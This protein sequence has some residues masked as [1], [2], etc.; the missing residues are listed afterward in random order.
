LPELFQSFCTALRAQFPDLQLF[1]IMRNLDDPAYWGGESFSP[2]TYRLVLQ[3]AARGLDIAATDSLMVTGEVGANLGLRRAGEDIDLLEA[4]AES[5]E[6][7]SLV[8]AFAVTVDGGIASPYDR[9]ADV[10][11]QNLS[12]VIL[13][14]EA[15]DTAGAGEMPIWFTHFGWTGA[16]AGVI[17]ASEQASYVE[18]GMRRA[19]SEWAWAG[20]IFNWQLVEAQEVDQSQLA[21]LADGQSLPLL[22]AMADFGNSSLGRSITTG[23]VPPDAPA[24]DYSGNWQDQ[25]LAGSLYR[26]VR[27]PDA[28]VTCTFYGTGISSVFRFGP[29]SGTAAYVVDQNGTGADEPLTGS[30]LLRF[31]LEDAFE[32]PVEL[33][34]GLPE[35]EHTVTIRLEGSGE[36]VVGGFLVRREQPLIWPIAVLVS[37]GLVA[38]FLG[39][40]SLAYL[41]AEHVDLIE[42]RSDSPERTPLPSMPDW[43]PDPRFRR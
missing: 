10:E 7:R 2:L 22:A 8:D 16:E 38:L 1:Q 5:P 40:R 3:A 19:R 33:A 28:A 12:R 34:A 26:T 4:L 36:L 32:D 27:D 30:V 39:L 11:T 6:I 14:R 24:C 43:R 42:P 29:D 31:G 25:F 18:S 23:F 20:L 13:I 17:S 37:A 21:L 35:G 41:A 9:R 15:I